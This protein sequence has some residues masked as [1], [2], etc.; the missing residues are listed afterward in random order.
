MGTD[1]KQSVKDELRLM[2][3]AM[4]KAN[5]FTEALRNLV[6]KYDQS[7]QQMLPST[8][9]DNIVFSLRTFLIYKLLIDECGYWGERL[10]NKAQ[11]AFEKA[12]KEKV[13][14]LKA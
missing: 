5:S 12:L 3:N 1:I 13:E 10:E 6:G 8:D 4:K 11:E 14:K 7:L 9:C 2:A